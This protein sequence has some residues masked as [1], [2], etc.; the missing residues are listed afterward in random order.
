[1]R[2]GGIMQKDK[3]KKSSLATTLKWLDR[4]YPEY[5]EL[6]GQV[7]VALRPRWIIEKVGAIHEKGTSET[8]G[9]LLSMYSCYYFQNH[10]QQF[11]M[12]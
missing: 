2:G 10:F 11:F 6:Q 12:L 9:S 8:L 5:D 1:M 7:P 3:E 4:R